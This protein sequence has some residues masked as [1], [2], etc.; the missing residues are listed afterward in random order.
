MG[1]MFNYVSD[2]EGIKPILERVLARWDEVVRPSKRC[3]AYR[4]AL[5]VSTQPLEKNVLASTLVTKFLY[6]GEHTFGNTFPMVG[7]I[8]LNS[9]Y[10]Y[11]YLKEEQLY[12]VLLHEVGHV[13]GIGT[14]WDLPKSPLT[15]YREDNKEK[16]YYTGESALREYKSYYP[17]SELVGI[18]LEDD[19]GE[20]T[21][22]SHPEEDMNRKISDKP[23]PGL[24]DELMTGWIH[25]LVSLSRITLGFLE[26]IG[27]IV[28]YS[29]A[30]PFHS[31]Y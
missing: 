5:H 6:L 8:V 30:D 7:A 26:D 18:P 10:L 28:D 27:Y 13:L 19:G 29:K 22:D 3:K 1:S 14:I 21:Q 12:A 16:Y 9:T 11:G 24:Q 23:H 20:G 4:I 25:S 31:S 2:E 17:T 15:L